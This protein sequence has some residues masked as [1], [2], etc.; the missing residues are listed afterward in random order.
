M[1]AA[2][3]RVRL[4]SGDDG[5]VVLGD[6]GQEQERDQE[7]EGGQGGADGESVMEHADAGG[8]DLLGVAGGGLR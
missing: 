1:V 7:G 8:F 5:S 6:G 3:G 4:R 2:A